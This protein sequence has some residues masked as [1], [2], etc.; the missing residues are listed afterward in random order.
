[1]YMQIN[2][3]DHALSVRMAVSLSGCVH[4]RRQ[5]KL[6]GS[7]IGSGKK[8]VLGKIEGKISL[9]GL[10]CE[11][12]SIYIVQLRESLNLTIVQSYLTKNFMTES[13]QLHLQTRGSGGGDG[14]LGGGGGALRCFV[15]P[16]GTSFIIHV[17]LHVDHSPE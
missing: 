16:L 1:M 4:C 8:R 2:F 13:K 17:H 9:N 10:K 6:T 5:L 12:V 7:R 14:V 3:T 11:N 15:L